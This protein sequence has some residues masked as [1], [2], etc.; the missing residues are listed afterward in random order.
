[1]LTEE[2][3]LAVRVSGAYR[4]AA[5][6]GDVFAR[7]AVADA[8]ATVGLVERRWETVRRV[9]AWLVARQAAMI[10]SASAPTVPATRTEAAAALGLHETTVG[11]VVAGRTILLPEGRAVAMADLF[12][13]PSSGAVE[14]LRQLI[15]AEPQP[16]SDGDLAAALARAGHP[17]ARRTVVKYRRRLG[18]PAAARR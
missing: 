5:A 7:A 17:V 12:P 8:L 6:D 10:R 13:S 11:R 18:V 16:L 4:A 15:G 2:A 9:A 3:T 14:A 1:V